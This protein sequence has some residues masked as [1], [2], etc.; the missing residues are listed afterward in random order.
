M[1][2]FKNQVRA[3]KKSKTG[4]EQKD[5]LNET[6]AFACIN[7][8]HA[9][10]EHNQ[11]QMAIQHYKKASEI[12]RGRGDKEFEANAYIWLGCAYKE[13]NQVKTAIEYYEKALALDI[14]RE[15][16]SNEAKAYMWLGNKHVHK[17]ST[18]I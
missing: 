17:V 11:I 8:G 5:K 3:M 6:T 12:A 1:K 15:D 14:E 9:C 16:R 7:L 4:K 10:K 2:K 13:N 18:C